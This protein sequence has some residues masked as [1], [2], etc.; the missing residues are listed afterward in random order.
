MLTLDSAHLLDNDNFKT[1]L[2]LLL[3]VHHPKVLEVG[4]GM[5]F[6][7]AID[8]ECF[9]E[10][11]NRRSVITTVFQKD[12]RDANKLYQINAYLKFSINAQFG[13]EFFLPLRWFNRNPMSQ[14]FGTVITL[15]VPHYLAHNFNDDILDFYS[16][17]SQQF[18]KSMPM[19]VRKNDQVAKEYFVEWSNRFAYYV[20]QLY[21]TYLDNE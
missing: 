1:Y 8:L 14:S 21:T 16:F 20:V 19:F 11:I 17:S 12:F 9:H 3:S 13:V 10:P 15:K 18:Q 6:Y 4:L 2:H 7:E 5:L